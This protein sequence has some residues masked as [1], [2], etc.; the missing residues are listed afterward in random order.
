M[1]RF[2]R[3]RGTRMSDDRSE[4]KSL[5]FRKCSVN[6][7]GAVILGLALL[8]S[9]GTMHANAATISTLFASNNNGAPGGAVYFD[10]IVGPNAISITGLETN[11]SETGVFPG[12]EVYTGL[13]SAFGNETNAGFWTLASTGTLNALG[14]NAMSPVALTSNIFLSAGT[15]YG[16]ALVMPASASHDY[17][18]TGENGALAS[19]SNAD[20]TLNFGSAT[21]APFTTAPP[22]GGNGGLFSPRTWNGTI[23][24]ETR[25]SAVPLPAAVWLFLSALGG[26]GLFGWRRRDTA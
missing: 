13:G 10:L 24:Y 19:Y 25:V 18:N 4:N 8:V 14:L 20:L 1:L 12:F 22:P 21:N 2:L 7:A 5:S 23:E 15:S 6:A 16:I 9:A 11:T 17:T 26:L 3:W